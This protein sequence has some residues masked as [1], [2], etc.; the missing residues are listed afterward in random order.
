M[1][2][3]M[4]LV[5]RTCDRLFWRR[6]YISYGSANSGTIGLSA[7][8]RTVLLLVLLLAGQ[9]QIDIDHMIAACT[10]RLFAPCLLGCPSQLPNR[11]SA[12]TSRRQDSAVE[13][14]SDFT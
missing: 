7:S 4:I 14:T 10:P 5:V 6:I 11:P 2:D 9:S 13:D 3:A 12:G 1:V 8:C